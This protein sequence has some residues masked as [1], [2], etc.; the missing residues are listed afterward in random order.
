MGADWLKNY[1]PRWSRCGLARDCS[2][3]RECAEPGEE[4]ALLQATGCD[5]R[6]RATK[7][8]PVPARKDLGDC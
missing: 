6:R 5:L 7:E 2:S 4:K 8:G 1:L 3:R